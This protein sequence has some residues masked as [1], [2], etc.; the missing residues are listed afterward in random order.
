MRLSI[1]PLRIVSDYMAGIDSSLGSPD[2]R[3][4]QELCKDEKNRKQ[5]VEKEKKMV[6]EL[7]KLK[8]T[9]VED[10]TDSY[11]CKRRN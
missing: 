4:T 5:I 2:P 10:R 8:P 1:N 11:G 7:R 3:L 9:R 6:C